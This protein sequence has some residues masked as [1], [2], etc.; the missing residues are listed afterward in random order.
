MTERARAWME[1]MAKE[2]CICHAAKRPKN[3]FCPSCYF[4]LPKAMQHAL[5]QTFGDG[6]E[7]A[8]AA[9]RA[10]LENRQQ[11]RAVTA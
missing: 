7:E 5:W 3:G 8:H 9:A 10:W 1:F 6:Y 2:C 4:S 11:K